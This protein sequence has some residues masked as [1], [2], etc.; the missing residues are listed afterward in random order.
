ME[1]PFQ[2][3]R[4][5]MVGVGQA[6]PSRLTG[7]RNTADPRRARS[8]GGIF[9]DSTGLDDGSFRLEISIEHQRT[10]VTLDVSRRATEPRVSPRS[11]RS[12]LHI[13]LPSCGLESSRFE[14]P[15]YRS[16]SPP[17]SPDLSRIE[18][19]PLLRP[20]SPLALV[21]RPCSPVLAGHGAAFRIYPR[22]WRSRRRSADFT[23]S[24]RR[25]LPRVRSVVT[26]RLSKNGAHPLLLLR[27]AVW[28]R[29][30]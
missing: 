15:R 28:I 11:G 10:G 2:L 23:S 6:D 26:T 17:D 8:S 19:S 18:D 22:V 5:A 7:S 25:F 13:R 27:G 24:S 9:D 1:A 21:R 20:V 16:R 3:E 14:R 29:S 4:D 30:R 12:N